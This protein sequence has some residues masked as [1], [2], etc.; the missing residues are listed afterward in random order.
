MKR[1][2]C[3]KRQTL[4]TYDMN[5]ERIA[6]IVRLSVHLTLIAAFLVY[7]FKAEWS[8]AFYTACIFFLVQLPLILKERFKLAIPLALDASIGAFIFLTLFLGA[9]QNF[10][11][12]FPIYD[13]IL[14]FQS[15]FLFSI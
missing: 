7:L 13:S 5:P 10:Y 1:L 8:S 15:G 4:Y 9:L 12:R 2:F 14:H 6:R 11:G 3:L